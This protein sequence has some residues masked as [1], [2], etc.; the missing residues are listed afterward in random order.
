MRS[1]YQVSKE[2]ETNNPFISLGKD[3][4]RGEEGKIKGINLR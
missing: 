2:S 3:K 4:N 1:K